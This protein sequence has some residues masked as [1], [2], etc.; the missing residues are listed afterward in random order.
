[1]WIHVYPNWKAN[2]NSR[3]G[4]RRSFSYETKVSNKIIYHNNQNEFIVPNH[5]KKKDYF[6]DSSLFQL[7]NELE[8]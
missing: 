2:L 3:N 5:E 8:F 6:M 1:M 7:K 4:R